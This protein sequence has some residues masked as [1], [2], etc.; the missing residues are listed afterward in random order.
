MTVAEAIVNDDIG[1]DKRRELYRSQLEIRL[2][3]KRAYDLFLQ[4]LVKGTSHLSLGQEAI[5]AGFAGA[6]KKGD[7]SFCT[8]RGHAHT[9]ARGVS[10]EKVLGELMQR[11]NGLMRGKGGSMHL[12][13]VD[14]GVMGSYAIIGAHLP[15]ACGAAWRAQYLGQDDVTVCFFGDGTTNIGA[16]HEAVNFAKV[17]MLPVVFVCE[18]NL[19]MEYTPIGDVTAVEHPAADRA[20]AYGLERIIVDGNDADAVYRVAQTA[21]AKARA[22]QGPSLIECMTY[23]HSGHSRADPG[24]YRPKGELEKWLKHDP[25]KLYRQR[26]GEFGI[27]EADIAAIDTDV[28]KQVD[29]ATEACKAAGLPPES[30]LC[31]DVYADGG[32]AWRN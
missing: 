24:A 29:E 17:W 8:Y 20:A 12:T 13:S 16:F 25:I 27:A 15:I 18:N 30:I 22:G 7:L 23:R 3:E 5:A 26:L 14:H 32:W 31:T 19:Y 10:M 11:D 21:F 1:L 6:M 9:L 2:F 28:A 4:N